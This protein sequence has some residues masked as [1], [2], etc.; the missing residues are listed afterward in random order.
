M[1]E[2]VKEL[3]G[4]KCWDSNNIDSYLKGFQAETKENFQL[5]SV[6]TK[7][8]TLEKLSVINGNLGEATGDASFEELVNAF[9]DKKVKFVCIT[10]DS[11]TGKTHLIELLS[12]KWE[13]EKNNLGLHESEVIV[14]LDRD[15]TNLKKFLETLINY[16]PRN[17]QKKYTEQLKDLDDTINK[18]E[19]E[20]RERLLFELAFLMEENIKSV[21]G[22][23][24]E[25]IIKWRKDIIKGFRAY[26]TDE[27]QKNYFLSDNKAIAKHVKEIKEGKEFD[28]DNDY[29]FEESDLLIEDIDIDHIKSTASDLVKEFVI[30]FYAADS[31]FVK[32]CL[33][34][35]NQNLKQACENLYKNNSV[36]VLDL[37][38]EIRE[39]F[40]KQDKTILLIIQDLSTHMNMG[41]RELFQ[42]VI[43][44]N[45]KDE[46]SLAEI[47]ILAAGTEGSINR[48]DETVLTRIFVGI[49]H[50]YRI[51]SEISQN[52]SESLDEFY[53][54]LTVNHLNA[55]R[56]SEA[57]LKKA[58]KKTTKDQNTIDQIFQPNVW[59]DN[60]CNDCE[61]REECHNTFGSRKV[62]NSKDGEEQTIGFYPLTKEVVIRNVRIKKNKLTPREFQKTVLKGTFQSQTTSD[63]EE[64]ILENIGSKSFP[65][66]QWREFIHGT[67]KFAE[68]DG[69]KM[70]DSVLK[71]QVEKEEI[72][73]EQLI[74]ALEEFHNFDEILNTP[75]L[76]VLGFNQINQDA[77][78]IDDLK[79]L[80]GSKVI[81][82]VQTKSSDEKIRNLLN[83]IEDWDGDAKLSANVR[84]EIK[85]ILIKF[86]KPL[87]YEFSITL[88]HE[89][90]V[91]RTDIDKIT[92]IYFLNTDTQY[93][94]D[95]IFIDQSDKPLLISLLR[96]NT[97]K[98][99]KYINDF[100]SLKD[101]LLKK[102]T[103]WYEAIKKNH[104]DFEDLNLI[105][106]FYL[107]KFLV[108]FGL[109]EKKD[110]ED[111][112]NFVKTELFQR[113]SILNEID[114]SSYKTVESCIK[115]LLKVWY[116]KIDE[117]PQNFKV[118]M[119]DIKYIYDIYNYL[120]ENKADLFSRE[121]SDFK[122]GLE[123]DSVLEKATNEKIL[124]KNR[125]TTLQ[126]NLEKLQK[127][128]A[129]TA[130]SLKD[131]ISEDIYQ[132]NE[133]FDLKS[134]AKDY[135]TFQS[136]NY[137]NRS[138]DPVVK[139]YAESIYKLISSENITTN[140]IIELKNDFEAN[141]ESIQLFRK[142]RNTIFAKEGTFKEI[143]HF[144]QVS[145]EN[146]AKYKPVEKDSDLRDKIIKEIEEM[147]NELQDLSWLKIWK[148]S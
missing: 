128:L 111:F 79:L 121:V 85:S 26:L 48:I 66:K 44:E 88:G 35:V 34:L 101:N 119:R 55:F 36:D 45:S 115:E 78:S 103:K 63:I 133:D 11:G 107:L 141:L 56:N 50:V 68:F 120:D 60:I 51:S 113:L 38:K 104:V 145:S 106:L 4:Y 112:N 32:I 46:P 108:Y 22:P 135:L 102:Y 70:F 81:E 31:I 143:L 77:V 86:I 99:E 73:A 96:L 42:A 138:V 130:D 54:D 37:V 134:Y 41:L 97:V 92:K 95:D 59:V 61:V 20:L 17:N 16:I 122:S 21:K 98:G 2:K 49:N 91:E 14:K 89:K 30:D 72:D 6:N 39:E 139:E 33:D 71:A 129:K 146:I 140:K 142:Y 1:A 24:R 84:S 23:D 137:D 52:K 25:K 9:N 64:D 53:L 132:I 136:A 58:Y 5:F 3:K 117:E 110:T 94:D 127:A 114:E 116:E 10:G 82:T 83:K 67:S 27:S 144:L 105:I 19:K 147:E 28:E 90:I 93:L 109:I 126:K 40:A 15:K 80:E 18:P 148:N 125:L 131:D 7:F 12:R 100:I 75:L 118:E 57:N 69:V 65:T 8:P 43:S 123:Q 13:E 47:R 124:N 74:V 76:Q 87:F 29:V 62:Q